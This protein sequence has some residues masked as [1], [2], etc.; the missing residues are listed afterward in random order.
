MGLGK[1]LDLHWMKEV[2]GGKGESDDQAT[3][4]M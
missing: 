3:Y 4:V 2:A 1:S